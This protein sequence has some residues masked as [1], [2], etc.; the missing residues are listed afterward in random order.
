MC[1]IFFV[2]ITMV[3]LYITLF[4]GNVEIKFMKSSQGIL[5]WFGKRDNSNFQVNIGSPTESNEIIF[6]KSWNKIIPY[7]CILEKNTYDQQLATSFDPSVWSYREDISVF[8]LRQ[9]LI[10]VNILKNIKMR[11]PTQLLAKT[12]IKDFLVPVQNYSRQIFPP[13]FLFPLKLLGK[14]L[15]LL[16]RVVVTFTLRIALWPNSLPQ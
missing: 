7:T 15:S 12:P 3:L 2:K 10:D 14:N 1:V 6:S 4:C 13:G 9:E 11:R 5:W 8:V 16:F